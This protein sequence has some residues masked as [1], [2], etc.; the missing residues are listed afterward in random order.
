MSY[1]PTKSDILT[2]P[3]LLSLIRLLLV[4]LI[5][6]L[7]FKQK[8]YWALGVI[9]FSGLTDVVDG[10]IARKFNMI[11]DFGKFLDPLAD[12]VTQAA[13]IFCVCS[14]YRLVLLLIVIF[15]IK[16]SMMFIFGYVRLKVTDTVTSANWYGKVNTVA[17]YIILAL[18]IIFPNIPHPI[19][20]TLI[21]ICGA[22]M[23]FALIMYTRFYVK[24]LSD[25]K[26]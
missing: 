14:R 25:S 15:I 5:L 4:P 13:M 9:V 1:K 20:N 17:M 10:R 19:A 24:L 23:V 18:L 11:S 12:K 16:E 8:F 3:N 6:W 2:I 21:L 7:Y 22:F 26:K